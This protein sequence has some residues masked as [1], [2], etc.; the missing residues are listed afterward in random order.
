MFK[1]TT[2]ENALRII[3]A[4]MKGTNTITV[5]VLCGTGS[6]HE[7]RE[8]RGISHFLEHMLFEGTKNLF[9]LCHHH[10]VS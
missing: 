5:L 1:K 4:P 10:K 9:L 8:L 2:L 6:D 7:S 3:T